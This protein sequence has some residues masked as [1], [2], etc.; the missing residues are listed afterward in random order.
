MNSFSELYLRSSTRYYYYDV[1]E[2]PGLCKRVGG[3]LATLAEIQ[4]A[5]I[6]GW[7]VCGCGWLDNGLPT[8]VVSTLTP[9]YCG[10]HLHVCNHMIPPLYD[11]HCTVF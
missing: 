3:R 8:A 1:T 5:S 2:S 11:V 9:Q 10:S 7:D 4:N 6:S